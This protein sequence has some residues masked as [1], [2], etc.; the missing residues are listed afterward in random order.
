MIQIYKPEHAPTL[1][2]KTKAKRTLKDNLSWIMITA[3]LIW[4]KAC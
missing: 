2:R 4:S 3:V 1:S